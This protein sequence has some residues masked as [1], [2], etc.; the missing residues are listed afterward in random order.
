MGFDFSDYFLFEETT[1]ED[2][3]EDDIFG[4][5][6]DDCDKDLDDNDEDW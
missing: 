4:D 2:T 6:Q 5:E 3:D 1:R